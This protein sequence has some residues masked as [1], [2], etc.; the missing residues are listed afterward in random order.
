MIEDVKQLFLEY[1]QSINIDLSFQNFEEEYE[2]LPGKY[3]PPHGAL[4]LALVDG[5]AAGCVALHKLSENICEMKRLY[6]RAQYRGLGIGKKLVNII[7]E[8]ASK[9]NY[10]YIRLDTLPTMKSAQA[11]YSSLGFYDIEPYVY[12]PIEG[13]RYMELKIE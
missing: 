3:G 12:N 8:Y 6:V 2:A 5:K 10:Q 1:A 7:I 9:M 11:L 13:T 4:I